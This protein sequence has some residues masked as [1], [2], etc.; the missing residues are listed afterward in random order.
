MIIEELKNIQSNKRKLRQ[1]GLLLMVLAAIIAFVL[2]KKGLSGS[3]YAISCDAVLLAVVAFCPELLKPFYR[4]WMSLAV[5]LGGCMTLVIMTILFFLVLT[6]V[7]LVAR[8]CG[9]T[10]FPCRPDDSVGTYW[11]DR[12]GIKFTKDYYEK[13]F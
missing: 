1:F 4:I 6:P 3:L 5:V 10:F 13:Q 2:H 11:N 7:S 9:K 8:I 12:S